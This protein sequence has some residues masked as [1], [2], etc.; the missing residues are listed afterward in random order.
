MIKARKTYRKTSMIHEFLNWCEA[1]VTSWN[2]PDLLFFFSHVMKI[3]RFPWK[4]KH[5]K[6]DSGQGLKGS[7]LN[8]WHIKWCLKYS[9]HMSFSKIYEQNRIRTPPP[10]P[11]TTLKMVS[12][13]FRT[14]SECITYYERYFYWWYACYLVKLN[15]YFFQNCALSLKPGNIILLLPSCPGLRS[16]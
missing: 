11:F 3:S 13:S 1:W 6:R 15:P 14:K 5:K 7:L 4:L 12:A 10:S 9:L 2:Y 8:L 16:S